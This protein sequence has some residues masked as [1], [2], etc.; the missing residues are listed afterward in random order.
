MRPNVT[1]QLVLVEYETPFG[2][3]TNTQGTPIIDLI[4]NTKWNGHRDGGGFPPIPGSIPDQFGQGLQITELPR[5][6]STEVWEFLNTTV[7]VHPIHVHLIEFQLLNRQAV[8]INPDT[9]QAAY[10]DDWST[11]FPGGTFNGEA[12]D[13]S[14]SPVTYAPHTWIPGY[15]PPRN[16]FTPNADG[17]LGGNRAFSPYLTG[18][19]IPPNAEEFG[20]KDTVKVYPGYVNRYIIRWA[21]QATAVNGVSP[22]QNLYSFDPTKGP[23]YMLHCHILDHEDN[24]MMRPY[25]PVK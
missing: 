5:V 11:D 20:W 14:W 23:A 2:N 21:P 19:V 4:N 6:G 16:Y 25:I 17:A 9:G 15:G 12:A 8:T 18:P 24:E 10:L 13:G 22:G 7:D 1:R 3:G